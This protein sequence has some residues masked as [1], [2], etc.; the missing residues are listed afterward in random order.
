M[1]GFSFYNRGIHL[2]NINE[3]AYPKFKNYVSREELYKIYT[4]SA[5][6]MILAQNSTKG[7]FSKTCFLIMYK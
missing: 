1:L 6:E 5:D 3:T 4:P 7:D 2:P